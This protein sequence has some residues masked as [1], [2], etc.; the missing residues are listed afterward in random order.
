MKNC[1]FYNDC[2]ECPQ[3]YRGKCHYE[4]S[5]GFLAGELR[6]NILIFIDRISASIKS[7]RW[8]SDK[9]Y[10]ELKRGN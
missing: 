3:Y 2:L 7:K 1:T 6:L 10:Y 4:K 5:G 8:I 9:E